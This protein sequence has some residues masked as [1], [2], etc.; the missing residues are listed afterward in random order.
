MLYVYKFA[1]DF[2][3]YADFFTYPNHLVWLKF[4]VCEIFDISEPIF[5]VLDLCA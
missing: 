2:R 1:R 5:L 3:G 4:C